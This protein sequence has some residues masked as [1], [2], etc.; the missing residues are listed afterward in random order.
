MCGLKKLINEIERLRAKMINIKEGKYF[1]DPEVVAAS[2]DLDVVLNKYQV[3]R[4]AG[5]NKNN[6]YENAKVMVVTFERQCLDSTTV[7]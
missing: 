5:K 4:E 3:M 7:V 1:T 6:R 2:Q